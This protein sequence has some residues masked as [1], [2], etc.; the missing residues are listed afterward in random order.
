ML[1][2]IWPLFIIISYV[3]AT[4]NGNVE[5]INNAVFEYTEM[6]VNLT[7]TLLGTMCLWNGLMEIALNTRLI[8]VI[9]KILNPFVNF[10]FSVKKE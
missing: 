5:K 1:N 4:I 7:I 6:A 8:N 2:V 9:N 10:L 3:Y